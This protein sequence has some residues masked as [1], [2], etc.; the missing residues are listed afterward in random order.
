MRIREGASHTDMVQD[1]IELAVLGE[2]YPDPLTQISFD[3]SNL[4]A[5]R[6]LSHTMSELLAASNGAAGDSSATKV[7]R[8]KAYSLLAD[9]DGIIREYG[10]YVFWKDEDKKSKYAL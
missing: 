5:A 6:S 2:K 8:D 3:L 10:R 9:K 1:L 4:E 7:T